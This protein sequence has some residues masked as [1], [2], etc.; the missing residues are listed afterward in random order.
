MAK[1]YEQTPWIEPDKTKYTGLIPPKE[2]FGKK[3][4]LF[5]GFNEL[6]DAFASMALAAKGADGKG[7]GLR[8]I[9]TG[10]K[11]AGNKDA[12]D[13][14]QNSTTFQGKG[15]SKEPLNIPITGFKFIDKPISKFV[16][17]NPW[18]QLLI[19]TQ[20]GQGGDPFGMSSWES[21]KIPQRRM[22]PSRN[23]MQRPRNR[24]EE[25]MEAKYTEENPHW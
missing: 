22:R 16:D 10:N 20:I 5:A 7:G 21:L 24:Y 18:S 17:K 4:D 19:G 15:K 6:K 11:D 1:N 14:T 2:A 23:W 13:T 3:K 25:L 12:S 9:F 8:E